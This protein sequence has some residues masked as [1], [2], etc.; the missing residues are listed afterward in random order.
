[1]HS[2]S[3]DD[4]LSAMGGDNVLDGGT[5]SNF[6][7]GASGDDQFFA[8][9]RNPK[10]DIWSTIAN[11]HNGD[12]AVVWGLTAHNHLD[13]QDNQ[14]ADNFQGLTLHTGNPTCSV[15][16]AGI[17]STDQLAMSYGHTQDLPNLPGSDYLM[18]TLK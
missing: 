18:I 3:G 9:D 15:T 17:H 4:A 2:G 1:M 6:L 8:D 14:G 7:V 10:A 13:W 5:G 12:V 16:F 11:F